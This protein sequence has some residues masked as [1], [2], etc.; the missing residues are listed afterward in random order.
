VF[1]STVTS[2]FSAAT[3]DN[4]H[5]RSLTKTPARKSPHVTISGNITKGQTVLGTPKLN[6]TKE[7]S[8]G[9][10]KQHDQKK[11]GSLLSHVTSQI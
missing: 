7:N 4:E 3:E 9:K 1:H 6:T 8:A 2:R 11:P 5:K 10:T